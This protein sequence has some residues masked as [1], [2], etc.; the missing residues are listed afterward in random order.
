MLVVPPSISIIHVGPIEGMTALAAIG[1]AVN[2]GWWLLLLE[3]SFYSCN[4]RLC[5]MLLIPT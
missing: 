1:N 5:S 4:R 3:L 2:L